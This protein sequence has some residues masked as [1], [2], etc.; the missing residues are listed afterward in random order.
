MFTPAVAGQQFQAASRTA[1]PSQSGKSTVSGRRKLSPATV[2]PCLQA[3]HFVAEVQ[4]DY[5]QSAL[6]AVA[7]AH[8][9]CTLSLVVQGLS[10]HLRQQVAAGFR[11]HIRAG[12]TA[13]AA[14]RW[15][16]RGLWSSLLRAWLDV[17]AGQPTLPCSGD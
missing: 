14:F 5:L 13:Q 12:R 4:A 16:L 2:L 3:A 7:A 6:Q 11:E 9:G 15:G 8:P 17:L 10:A 1:A